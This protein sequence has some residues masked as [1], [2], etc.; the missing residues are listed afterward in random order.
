MPI[1]KV[2]DKLVEF[3]YG[4]HDKSL[5]KEDKQDY[6]LIDAVDSPFVV[7]EVDVPLE[8]Q[9]IVPSSDTQK[10]GDY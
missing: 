9:F 10:S 4:A 7:D 8:I 1:K 3:N 6:V 2:I 5:F